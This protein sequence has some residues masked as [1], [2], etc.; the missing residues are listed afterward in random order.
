L[1][2]DLVGASIPGALD[3]PKLSRLPLHEL[4][5]GTEVRPLGSPGSSGAALLVKPGLAR[6]FSVNAGRAHVLAAVDDDVTV[7]GTIEAA[8]LGPRV[9][10]TR[11]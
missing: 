10:E 1:V 2:G 4:P 9:K 3:E 7:D 5:A 8:R 6:V 11:R